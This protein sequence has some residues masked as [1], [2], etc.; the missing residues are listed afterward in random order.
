MTLE[1]RV[2]KPI[3]PKSKVG[4]LTTLAAKGI[5]RALNYPKPQENV[6]QSEKFRNLRA[7]QP[8]QPA[9]MKRCVARFGGGF[10]VDATLERGMRYSNMEPTALSDRSKIKSIASPTTVGMLETVD[11]DGQATNLWRL[12]QPRCTIG[13]SAES[14]ICI[15][16]SSMAAVHAL[17]V[18]GKNHTLIRAMGGQVRIAG[19]SVREWLIDEPTMI[20]CGATRFVVYPAGHLR[21]GNSASH[22]VSAGTVADQAARLQSVHSSETRVGNELPSETDNRPT[23]DESAVQGRLPEPP[24]DAVVAPPAPA[25]VIAKL[26][27]NDVKTA[28]EPLHLA[29]QAASDGIIELTRRAN[30]SAAQ[31]VDFPPINSNLTEMTQ[32]I[33]TLEDRVSTISNYCENLLSSVSESIEGRLSRFDELLLK[34]SERP[35]ATIPQAST[36]WET[37][38]PDPYSSQGLNDYAESSEPTFAQPQQE[39]YNL[40]SDDEVPAQEE[41]PIQSWPADNTTFEEAHEDHFSHDES[42]Y[43]TQVPNASSYF[44]DIADLASPPI[45]VGQAH[46]EHQAYAFDNQG[47][48]QS[49]LSA[50]AYYSDATPDLTSPEVTEDSYSSHLAEEEVENETQKPELPAWYTESES[51]SSTDQEPSPQVDAPDSSWS[52]AQ[53]NPIYAEDSNQ[54]L[55]ES[56]AQPFRQEFELTPSDLESVSPTAHYEETIVAEESS[57]QEST[58]EAFAAVDYDEPVITAIESE[59]ASETL[60]E[61]VQEEVVEEE[62]DEIREESIEDYMARLLQRVKGTPDSAGPPTKSTSNA[63]KSRETVTSS[64]TR[65]E[66]TKSESPVLSGFDTPIIASVDVK[67]AE[68]APRQAAPE[69]AANL[70]ALRNLANDTARQALHNSSRKKNELVLIGK[71]AIAILGL[72]GAILLLVLN[73]F[74]ANVAMIGMIASFV[75]FLLWGYEAVVQ[76]KLLNASKVKEASD[77]ENA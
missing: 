63:T 51:A 50:H 21:T 9:D 48:Y 72:G 57:T 23:S 27:P 10:F 49:D 13:S 7:S 74:R 69:N 19:R 30:E 38:T 16:D 36:A 71:A 65:S 28:L 20:Q 52:T 46:D 12:S 26:D 15:D 5:P 22:R 59:T 32:A 17:I 4:N 31:I 60:Y 47:T 53:L 67:P 68:F 18:F 3:R 66:P 34:L 54:W 37:Q 25:F 77:N 75:V 43:P 11:N 14:L 39:A 6:K 35:E 44:S 40:P 42:V 73:G 29:V 24:Q 58:F 62:E 64:I 76:Y 33:E 61:E 70:A 1:K 2:S 56:E 55:A 8:H 41:E 45:P